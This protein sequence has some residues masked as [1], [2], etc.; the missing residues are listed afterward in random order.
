RFHPVL[1]YVKAHNG[2]DYRAA[3]GTPVWAVADGTVTRSGYD[4]ANGH[5]VCLRH[6]NGFETCYIHLS[7][8]MVRPGQRVHQ[9]DVIALTGNTGRSTG[10]HLHYALKRH[11]GY[12]NPLNQNFPRA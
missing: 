9:K 4:P 1:K 12:V 2:V 8:R 11:G 10:P 7:K 6:M 3:V 5:A